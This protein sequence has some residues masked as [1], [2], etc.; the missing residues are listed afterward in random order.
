MEIRKTKGI[1]KIISL[2]VI[3]LLVTCFPTV[4]NA[5][6]AT[7]AEQQFRE[8]YLNLLET[9]DT[10]VQDISEWNLPYM[11]CYYI[12][13]DVKQNEGFIPYQSYN[14]YNLISVDRM[15]NKDNTPYL[16]QFHMNQEDTGF[17][18]R[19]ATVQK[20]I[21]EMQS[22]LDDKMTDLINWSFF[23]NMW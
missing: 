5:A 16:M 11:T 14:E 18:E 22:K 7:D 13:E 6:T 4:S 10:S 21:A 1:K 3:S 20:I 17:Q 9:G 19:Y 15:E 12:M 8:L 2:L 23:M